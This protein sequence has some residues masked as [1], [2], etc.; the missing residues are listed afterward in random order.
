MSKATKKSKQAANRGKAR[1]AA[2]TPDQ[3]RESAR[4][5]ARARWAT[6]AAGA[7]L[8]PKE[9]HSGVLS[10]GGVDLPC[11]VL[12]TG[13]RVFSQRGMLSAFGAGKPSGKPGADDR[14]EQLPGFLGSKS[15]FPFISEQLV[16]TIRMPIV[17]QPK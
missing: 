5:A 15:V 3:R 9:T 2:L 12:D 4:Y 1:A 14:A 11:A 7:P 8:L 17:Y 13:T 10:V 6:Q 16:T